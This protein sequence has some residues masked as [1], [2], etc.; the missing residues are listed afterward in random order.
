MTIVRDVCI[1][2]LMEG[3]RQ[4]AQFPAPNKFYNIR[5]LLGDPSNF[6]SASAFGSQGRQFFDSATPHEKVADIFAVAQR[7]GLMK[8]AIVTEA[9]R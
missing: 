8:I 7:A 4:F 1:F 5:V 9:Q 2:A 6:G 3:V